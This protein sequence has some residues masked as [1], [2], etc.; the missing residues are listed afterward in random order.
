M[1]NYFCIAALLLSSATYSSATYATNPLTIVTEDWPPFQFAEGERITGMATEVVEAVL[2]EAQLQGEIAMYPWARAYNLALRDK[3]TAIYSLARTNEREHHFLWIGEVAPYKIH[4]WKLRKRRDI[5]I[6]TLEDAKRYK[7]GGV[8]KDVKTEYLI[9]NHGFRT[10]QH[11]YIVHQDMLNLKMLLGGRIDYFPHGEVD[12]KAKL[13]QLGVSLDEVEQ[14]YTFNEGPLSKDLYL[15]LNIESD[16]ALAKKLT[17]ALEKV[18]Q[19]G[20]YERIRKK[21]LK[22]E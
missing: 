2:Q 20:T 11:I 7:M 6:N 19:N 12:M 15:A 4:L 21:Y 1:I 18:R 9:A 8:Y 14:V 10:G 22:E 17:R 13:R 3:N 16:Q 5:V